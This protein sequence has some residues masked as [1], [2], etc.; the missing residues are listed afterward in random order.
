MENHFIIIIGII[1]VISSLAF[2]LKSCKESTEFKK[3]CK[4]VCYPLHAKQI[5]GL[6]N[7]R[8]DT[9]WIIKKIDEE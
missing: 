9:G 2:G 6:C 5:D 7:C 3:L 1:I 4:T 8:T